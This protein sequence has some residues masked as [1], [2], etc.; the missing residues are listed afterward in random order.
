MEDAG[1]FY[2]IWCILR[3]F[4]IFFD[5]LVYFWELGTIFPVLV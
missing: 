5:P 4:C 3:L 1:I 2:D